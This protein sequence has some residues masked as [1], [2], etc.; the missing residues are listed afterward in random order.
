[1]KL[2]K[3][4]KPYWLFALLSPILMIG[5]VV[6]DL[7]QPQLMRTIVN[8]GVLGGDMELIIRTGL[9]MLGLVILGGLSG[10]ACAVTAT[11]ASQSFGHD[12]RVDTYNRVMSLSLEQTDDFTL[13]YVDRN[14]IYNGAGFIPLYQVLCEKSHYS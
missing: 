14:V 12:L 9:L 13:L 1:M 3:Y 4:L 5:E 2:I 6:V 8:E 7:M 11:Y 10:F